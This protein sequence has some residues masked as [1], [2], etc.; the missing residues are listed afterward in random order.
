MVGYDLLLK[1]FKDFTGKSPE[2]GDR[3]VMA[4]YRSFS[5]F[6][7]WGAKI[8]SQSNTTPILLYKSYKHTEKSN[9]ISPS[10][11]DKSSFTNACI[12]L[13]K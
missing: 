13:N 12:I 2:I 6:Y 8:K 1:E 11:M 3:F 10:E 4:N 7:V 5:Y 9:D